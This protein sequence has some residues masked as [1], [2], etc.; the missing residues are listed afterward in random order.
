MRSLC[1]ERLLLVFVFLF[2]LYLARVV[3][4]QVRIERLRS[5]II[6]VIGFGAGVQNGLSI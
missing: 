1:R 3:V 4:D 6:L 2:V 5:G